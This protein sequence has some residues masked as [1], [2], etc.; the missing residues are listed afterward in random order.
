MYEAKVKNPM[1]DVKGNATVNGLIYTAIIIAS[2]LLN[3]L[4]L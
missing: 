1:D 2:M 4:V 3:H